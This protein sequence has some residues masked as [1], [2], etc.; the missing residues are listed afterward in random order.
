MGSYPGWPESKHLKR[1]S[2]NLGLPRGRLQP[3]TKGTGARTSAQPHYDF[4]LATGH[5][6]KT[7]SSLVTMHPPPLCHLEECPSSDLTLGIHT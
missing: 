7:S 2:Q 6:G 5:C 3:P 4:F 1:L